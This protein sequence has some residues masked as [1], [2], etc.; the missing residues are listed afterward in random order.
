MDHTSADGDSDHKCYP[1]K[2]SLGLGR[3][4]ARYAWCAHV[5]TKHFPDNRRICRGRLRCVQGIQAVKPSL[6]GG[7]PNGVS[8]HWNEYL[9]RGEDVMVMKICDYCGKE[10]DEALERT[11]D[12]GCPACPK[13]VQ[14]EEENHKKEE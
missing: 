4:F 1:R 3:G 5:G 14:Q 10:Y 7:T 12:N 2:D 11:L 9:K 8:F 6:R 13:C